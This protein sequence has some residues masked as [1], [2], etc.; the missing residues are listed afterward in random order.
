V[1]EAFFGTATAAFPEAV[2]IADFV[3][4]ENTAAAADSATTTA[5]AALDQHKL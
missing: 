5:G 3:S 1:A 4:A 2:G